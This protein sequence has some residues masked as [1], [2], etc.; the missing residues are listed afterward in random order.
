MP[1]S[2]LPTVIVSS[3]STLTASGTTMLVLAPE[4]DLARSGGII[5]IVL[6]AMAAAT[7]AHYTLLDRRL[8]RLEG[9]GRSI[10]NCERAVLDA[11]DES[12]APP[13]GP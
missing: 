8:S 3:V 12:N 7:A 1:L 5:G 9:L 13:P 11:L 10:V 4:S 2:V 6:A